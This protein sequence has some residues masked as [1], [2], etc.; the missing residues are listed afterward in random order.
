MPH[1]AT[2][3]SERFMGDVAAA[4]MRANADKQRRYQ[5][6]R[7][8]RSVE[9]LLGVEINKWYQCPQA[10]DSVITHLWT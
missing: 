6:L 10:L 1:A 3:I 4:Q 8:R 7:P 5:R 9:T 2:I